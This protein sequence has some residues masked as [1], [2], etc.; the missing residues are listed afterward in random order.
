VLLL[1]TGWPAQ[2][3]QKEVRKARQFPPLRLCTIVWG[4]AFA[5]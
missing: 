4:V 2:A 1:R 5:H 3:K